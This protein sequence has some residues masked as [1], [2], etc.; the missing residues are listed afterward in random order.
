[1]LLSFK[2]KKN[3]GFFPNSEIKF[4]I[5]GIGGI[6]MSAI[7][8]VLHHHGY[9]VQGSDLNENNNIK[10]LKELGI[11]CYIGPHDAKNIEKM[12]IVAY[13]SAVKKDNPEFIA[14]SHPYVTPSNSSSN[15]LQ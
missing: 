4:H 10:K 12:D 7:A 8:Q 13:S 9:Y 14:A 6:G 1:M 3:L 5:I 15:D 11:R 2:S